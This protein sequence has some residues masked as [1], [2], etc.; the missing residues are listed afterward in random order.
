MALP[1]YGY[2][3][4]TQGY[5]AGHP[6][7]DIVSYAAG[8]AVPGDSLVRAVADGVVGQSLLIQN[9]NDRTWE[10]GNYVRV[11]SDDKR[12]Y[13]FYCH[14]AQRL[15]STGQRVKAGDAVGVMGDT[16]YSFGAHVHLE[17]RNFGT[18][19]AVDPRV[20]CGEIPA[21]PGS[22]VQYTPAASGGASPGG[23]SAGGSSAGGAYTVARGDSLSSIAARYGTTWQALAAA[24]PSIAD[25]NLIYPGQQ[26]TI[27]GASGGAGF[28]VGGRVRVKRGA[29]DY[30]GAG[31]AA[32]V[33]DTVYYIRELSGD[34]AV[35]APAMSGAITAAVATGNLTNA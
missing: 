14:L 26:I 13:V 5:T 9:K 15:V 19:Q 23:S 8:A 28:A 31:L 17:V 16:G 20:L 4:L 2:N 11:D 18:T 12:F 6:A 24:N 34:R 1:F 3:R 29:A 32:F 21:T 35:I 33:Y 25:P 30:N 27:P 10:W 7:Y 22:V